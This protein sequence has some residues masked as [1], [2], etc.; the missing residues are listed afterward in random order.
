MEHTSIELV[1]EQNMKAVIGVVHLQALPGSPESNGD[2]PFLQAQADAHAL[3]E[4]GVDAIIFENFGDAPFHSNTTPAH[5][6]SAMTAVILHASKDL[7]IPIGVNVLR[8]DAIAALAI[9]KSTGAGFIRVNILSGVYAT[10]QGIIEGDA[11]GVLR[12]RAMLAPGVKILADVYVKHAQCLSHSSIED[13]ARDIVHR[14]LADA[15]I[16]TGS[17]TGSEVEAGLPEKI[18]QLE[19]GVP[20]LIG[21]GVTPSNARKLM[22]AS[23]GL[24]VGTYFKV[25]GGVDS[26]RVKEVTGAINEK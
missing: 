8:N 10:D 24:I 12:Y 20:I 2:L 5:T 17:A 18:A 25:Q 22:Q 9:A 3:Y 4:G 14:G 6:I 15:L 19:L 23:Q 26:S 11:A 1:L 13:A 16:I 21:S 7:P